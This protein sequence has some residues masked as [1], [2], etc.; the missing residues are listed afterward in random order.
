MSLTCKPIKQVFIHETM[1]WGGAEVLRKT[2]AN[3]IQAHADWQNQ[4]EIVI[5]CLTKKG[6]VAE[7]LEKQGM[8][9]IALNWRQEQSSWRLILRLK[10]LLKGLQPDVVH[11]CLF[12]AHKH[13][14]LAARLAGCKHVMIEEHGDNQWMGRQEKWTNRI[15]SYLATKVIA[16]SNAQA[17][18]LIESMPYS[19]DK[20]VVLPNCIDVGLLSQD[21]QGGGAGPMKL[22]AVGG[23]REVKQIP[24][25]LKAFALLLE[26]RPD[27]S[28]SIV[29]EGGLKESLICLAH[30][31]GVN[32]KVHFLGLRQD[33]ADI[34]QHSDVYVHAG[35]SE[36]FCIAMAEAMYSGCACVAP[37]CAV[38]R[39]LSDDGR[40]I[41]LFEVGNEVAMATALLN[42]LQVKDEMC[43]LGQQASKYAAVAFHPKQY[44]SGLRELYKLT[45]VL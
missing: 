34:L 44:V 40:V 41:R 17:A 13:A 7:L 4:F 29:G 24:L 25:L 9:V 28:L 20:V 14:V 21:H 31:L 12:Q 11:S 35:H 26:R 8:Q 10:R 37:D 38:F 15:L 2:F 6:P 45:G 27:C 22:V 32:E 43:E 23:L 33:V 16:V 19:A 3:F 36:S 5:I 18:H 30:E 42:L 39:E 1:A